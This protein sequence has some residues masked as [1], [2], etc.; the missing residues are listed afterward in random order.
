MTAGVIMP[1][2]EESAASGLNRHLG[3]MGI[4]Q[5]KGAP[6]NDAVNDAVNDLPC[7]NHFWLTVAHP[8]TC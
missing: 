1:M 5:R 8:V 4:S 3:A 7:R 2:G 6:V